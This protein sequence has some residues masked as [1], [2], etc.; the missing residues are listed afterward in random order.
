M[1]WRVATLFEHIGLQH[2]VVAHAGQL[3]AV[4]AQHMRVVLQVMAELGVRCDLSSQGLSCARQLVEI[5]LLG[6]AGI[7]MRQRQIGRLAGVDA[8]RHADDAR[9]AVI[10]AGGLGVEGDQLGRFE[11][12]QPASKLRLRE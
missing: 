8:E 11:S 9:L 10:E 6:R 4:V 2:R 12:L 3:D 1:S 7:A 5:E